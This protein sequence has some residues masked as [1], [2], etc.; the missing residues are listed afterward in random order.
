MAQILVSPAERD[1]AI[2]ALGPVSS[3]P[4][5]WGVDLCWVA[6]GERFGVQRKAVPDLLASVSDGRLGMELGMMRQAKC[7]SLIIIEGRVQF[8][9]EGEMLGSGFGRPWDRRGWWGLQFGMQMDGAWIMSTASPTE[10]AE[11]TRA[12]KAWS[13]KSTHGG[14]TGRVG[15]KGLWGSQPTDRD[16]GVHLLTSFPGIGTGV[17]RDIWDHFGR[18]PLGFD[19]EAEELMK[20]KGLGKKRV[21]RMMRVLG[22]KD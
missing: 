5:K 4:E 17:A 22:R 10:T 18:V 6:H 13:E 14:W 19:V 9:V 20:V 21:L 1:P 15:V 16:F 7:V 2:L 11:M 8:T 3:L 12:F